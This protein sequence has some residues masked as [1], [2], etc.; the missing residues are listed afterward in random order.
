MLKTIFIVGTGGFL[1]SVA[2]Y[3]TQVLVEKYLHS[4]FPW[5]TFAANIAGC[6]IIG[7]AFAMSERG[8]LLSP[9]WRIFL[10]VGFCGGFTTFSSFAYNNLNM[11]AE[12]NYLQLFGNIGLSLFFGILAVYLGVI[13]IRLIYGQ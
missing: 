12:N 7:L 2:R 5:G 8:N 3:L 1:G 9:E 6:F 13:S 11:L 4:T 10:T